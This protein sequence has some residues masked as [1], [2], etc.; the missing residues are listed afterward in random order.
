MACV[1]PWPKWWYTGSFDGW[2]LTCDY[3]TIRKIE[4]LWTALVC[5]CS[6]ITVTLFH[7]VYQISFNLSIFSTGIK[8]WFIIQ[9]NYILPNLGWEIDRFLNHF[10]FLVLDVQMLCST[11]ILH[12]VLILIH[13]MALHSILLKIMNNTF[14]IIWNI[15]M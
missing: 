15:L 13:N 9:L 3:K 8:I 6:S 12:L 10:H 2:N 1:R 11:P 5:R 7:Q 4:M 14:V